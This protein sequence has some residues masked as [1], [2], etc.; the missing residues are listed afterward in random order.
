MRAFTKKEIIVA[1]CCIIF[2]IAALKEQNFGEVYVLQ[3]VS[4][5]S[6]LAASISR[7]DP[8]KAQNFAFGNKGFPHDMQCR[9]S[10]DITVG[11]KSGRRTNTWREGSSTL[12]ET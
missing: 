8:Q 6:V 5:F 3:I 9:P 2:L 4:Y 1:L 10:S 12:F 11:M 7:S